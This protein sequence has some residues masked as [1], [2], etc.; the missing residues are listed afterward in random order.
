MVWIHILKKN[1]HHCISL[2]SLRTEK[3]LH[4]TAGRQYPQQP[5]SVPPGSKA[6]CQQLSKAH[7]SATQGEMDQG[8][9][10]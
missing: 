1:N 2:L 9:G 3:E 5:E 10:V 7:N 6:H 8:Y 4:I